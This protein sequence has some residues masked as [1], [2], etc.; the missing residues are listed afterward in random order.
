MSGSLREWSG[1]PKYSYPTEE[2]RPRKIGHTFFLGLPINKETM[3]FDV[4]Q[5]GLRKRLDAARGK[6]P[7]DFTALREI[8]NSINAH[9]V[10]YGEPPVEFPPLKRTLREGLIIFLQKFNR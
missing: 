8:Q 9:L 3:E 2:Y 1:E 7:R 5:R 10:Q 4:E 6:M